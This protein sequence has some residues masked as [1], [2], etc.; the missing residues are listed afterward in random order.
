M[1]QEFLELPVIV[2]LFTFLKDSVR[3]VQFLSLTRE[4][5]EIWNGLKRHSKSLV[6]QEE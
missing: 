1:S 6:E 4:V 2:I 5:T 3:W